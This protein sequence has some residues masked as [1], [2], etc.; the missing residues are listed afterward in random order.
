MSVASPTNATIDTENVRVRRRTRWGFHL[1]DAVM[2][3][4]S[5]GTLRRRYGGA[6]DLALALARRRRISVVYGVFYDAAEP[7][8]IARSDLGDVQ[9]ERRVIEPPVGAE[10]L[11]GVAHRR[12]LDPLPT[13]NLSP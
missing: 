11:M 13:F 10:L 1:A 3:V 8:R 4:R 7:S 2:A 6:L 9:R 5:S 12:S